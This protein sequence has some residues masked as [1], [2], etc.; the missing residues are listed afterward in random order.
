M[1]DLIVVGGGPAGS[2]A[3]LSAAKQGLDTLI[4]E[5]ESFPRYK[6]CG[7]ALSQR[8]I[9]AL[10]CP[11]PAELC[12]R[13]ITGA[14]IH[15]KGWMAERRRPCHITTLVTRSR[16]DEFLLQKAV[17]AGAILKTERA[18]DFRDK[19]ESVSVKARSD[20]YRSRFL[21]IASG[22]QDALARRIQG[23]DRRESTGVCLVA[24]VAEDD[25]RI[26]ER[27]DGLLDIHFGVAE[28][29]YGW[30]FPHRGYYSVGIGGPLTRLHHP[31]RIMQQFL[32]DSGFPGGL[33]LSGHLIPQ[34]GN[35]RI[36][37]AGR[38]L[39]AGDA[40]GFVDPFSGEGIYYALSS[41]KIAGRL[42]GNAPDGT[43]AEEYRRE[44]NRQFG[45]DLRCALLF[46]RMMHSHPDI[47]LRILACREEVLDRY[48]DIAT[49]RLSYR[50]FLRWLVPRLP[51]SLL[52]SLH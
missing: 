52:R 25:A 39:L 30:I 50:G 14:R 20:V 23:P 6:P 47:F 49:D 10:D 46:S 45:D 1:Y 16:F 33:R 42:I 43:L 7:G 9:R 11:P 26:E 28:G 13:S 48:I 35:D 18:L 19:G 22:C 24:D 17:E 31:R 21:V 29:G 12:E 44:C 37:A 8:A 36:T 3:S 51:A 2:A 32:K 27:L 15:Y 4:L 34:G 41:G 40:A 5:K 38:V